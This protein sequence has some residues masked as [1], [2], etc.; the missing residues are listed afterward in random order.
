MKYIP[1]G[2]RKNFPAQTEAQ[3]EE[4]EARRPEKNEFNISVQPVRTAIRT[5]NASLLKFDGIIIQRT[6]PKTSLS[7]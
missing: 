3:P 1:K 4:K 7:N 6:C 5:Y 2:R